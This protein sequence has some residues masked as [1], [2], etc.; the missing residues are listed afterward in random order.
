MLGCAM[1]Q[2]LDTRCR[3]A[4]GRSA[5]LQS[6]VARLASQLLDAERARSLHSVCCC[7]QCVARQISHLL[8]RDMR[9]PLPE[10]AGVLSAAPPSQ[11]VLAGE[12]RVR[13]RRL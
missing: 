11:A 6:E 3:L 1:R 5:G 8:G 12:Q 2:S 9:A 7:T 13:T 10:H 4:S